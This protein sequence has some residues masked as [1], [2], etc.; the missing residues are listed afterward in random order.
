MSGLAGR[1][2]R[3]LRVELG[4]L[5]RRA[6]LNVVAASTFTPRPLR[7][8]LYRACGMAVRTPNVFPGL[9]IAGRPGN[10]D[11]GTGTFVNTGCFF[12]LV[13]EVSIGRDCQLGMQTMVVTSHHEAAGGEVSRRPV[14]RPVRI[15]D[16]VWTGARVTVLPGVRI[17]D[18]VVLAAGAVVTRDCPEPGLYAGVPARLVR[19][20]AP[21]GAP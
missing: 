15:G 12:E 14:G 13:A 16:R 5:T 9:Q 11:V 2:L 20:A 21:V 6:L 17:A 4:F 8:A 7:W 3:E 19:S 10:L 18:D 1:L